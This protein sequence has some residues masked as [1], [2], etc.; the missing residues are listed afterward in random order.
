MTDDEKF[1]ALVFNLYGITRHAYFS[2]Y[3]GHYFDRLS[4]MEDFRLR[5][6][7]TMRIGVDP[8]KQYVLHGDLLRFAFDEHKAIPIN[9]VG[10]LGMAVTTNAIRDISKA[11]FEALKDPRFCKV[12]SDHIFYGDTSQLLSFNAIIR[13]VRN[14]FSHSV[15]RNMTLNLEDFKQQKAWSKKN[16]L[17]EV[18]FFYDYSSPSTMLPAPIENYNFTITFKW[19]DVIE[20]KKFT[21]IIGYYEL[22]MLME[23]CFNAITTLQSNI[24][25]N[26]HKVTRVF[27]FSPHE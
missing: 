3:L 12:I 10:I 13:L 2:L 1:K 5:D 25:R 14:C 9:E 23:F 8:G 20:G 15:D 7:H 27:G 17:S 22:L 16:R 6:V 11:V 21:E 24:D 26:P 19:A 18:Y 4:R